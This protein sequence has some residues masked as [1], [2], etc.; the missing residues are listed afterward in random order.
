MI[1]TFLDSFR[2]INPHNLSS[3]LEFCLDEAPWHSSFTAHETRPS[4]EPAENCVTASC[5]FHSFLLFLNLACPPSPP[6]HHRTLLHHACNYGATGE[7]SVAKFS[8]AVRVGNGGFRVIQLEF[9]GLVTPLAVEPDLYWSWS[10]GLIVESR[11]LSLARTCHLCFD[12]ESHFSPYVTI[13]LV[14]ALHDMTFN[15]TGHLSLRYTVCSFF[16]LGLLILLV[17]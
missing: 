8:L 13:C 16:R 9:S 17:G 15:L 4:L 3:E 10:G 2:N 1:Q 6:S 14:P 11:P 5:T 7:M 12:Y